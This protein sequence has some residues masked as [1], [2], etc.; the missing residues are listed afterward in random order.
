MKNEIRVVQIFDEDKGRAVAVVQEPSLILV[1]NFT[2]VYAAAL[3]AV[4]TKTKLT[5]LLNANLSDTK[6]DY[7]SVYDGRSSWRLLPAFDFPDNPFGC[8]VAGTGLTHKNSALN[9]QMMHASGGDSKPTDSIVMYE[10]GVKQ[11]FP[12]AG[13]IGVQPEW[14]Y[15]GN[16]SVL[17]A[18]G[19]K[20]EVPAYANDGGEE[21]E[22]A[23]IYIVDEE[24]IP[25]RIGFATGNEFSDHVMEKKNYLYLAPSKLRQCAIGPELVI[26]GE[27]SDL[28]GTVSI[29]D[30]EA[31]RWSSA[32]KTGEQN[33]AHSLENLE[34]HHFKYA[35]HRLPLQAHVHFFGADAF[36]FGNNV[37]LQ[38][39][40]L[41][42][43]HWEGMGRPL[44]NSI[45]ISNEAE[46]LVPVRQL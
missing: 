30:G 12:A 11:G 34:Y 17:K 42:T 37:T 26:G 36:S 41:M 38:N 6:L 27:F 14:F 40:D 46:T 33:M 18:H 19:E 39:N 31:T 24:G 23:G 45:S 3:E 13:E 20:L 22:I 10:W 25:H 28:K 44:Q 32:I 2:S 1:K 29:S 21:P 16:G 43:V 15:K 9:R 5:D 7:D 4:R 35:G 8:L